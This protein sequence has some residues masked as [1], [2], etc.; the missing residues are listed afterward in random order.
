MSDEVT[1]TSRGFELVTFQ[2]RN[3]V[4]CSLQQSSAIAFDEPEDIDRPGSSMIWLGCDDADPKYFVPNGEPSWR[5]VKMP[6]QYVA[7]TRM[8][9]DRKRVKML[10]AHLQ[11]WLDTGGFADDSILNASE[12]SK[13]DYDQRKET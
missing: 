9:L 7:N 1:T 2:D 10:I 6:D 8:H 3:R 5:P 11:T 4:E 13:N 12:L